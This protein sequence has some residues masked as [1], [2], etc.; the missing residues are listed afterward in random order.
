L[1]REPR[2]LVN[3]HPGGPPISPVSVA[4]HSLTG[5]PRMNNLRSSYI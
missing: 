2:I 3:V 1:R 4:T 5:L